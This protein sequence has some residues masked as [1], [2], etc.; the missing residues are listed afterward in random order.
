MQGV[1][2]VS[3]GSR[4]TVCVTPNTVYSWGSGD[5]GQLGL[6]SF[7]GNDL[8][9]KIVALDGKNVQQVACG[10]YHTIFLTG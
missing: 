5:H 8:P 10:V 3:A 9:Q 7:D 4:H 1:R 2:Y 6:G